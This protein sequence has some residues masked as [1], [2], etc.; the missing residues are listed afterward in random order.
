[1]H[2]FT[3]PRGHVATIDKRPIGD[4]A[5]AVDLP[6]TLPQGFSQQLIS[7]LNTQQ[8][9]AY[10]YRSG[11][12][13]RVSFVLSSTSSAQFTIRE[14]VTELSNDPAHYD[15]ASLLKME[16]EFLVEIGVKKPSSLAPAPAKQPSPPPPPPTAPPTP[17]QTN[18]MYA[19]SVVAA[20]KRSKSPLYPDADDIGKLL[21][22]C[23]N[24]AEI[25][26]VYYDIANTPMNGQFPRP[27]VYKIPEVAAHKS[28]SRNLSA[29]RTAAIDKSSPVAAANAKHVPEVVAELKKG[30]PDLDT[31]KI[32]TALRNCTKLDDV[33]EVYYD[34]TNGRNGMPRYPN[35]DY[36]QEVKAHKAALK[37]LGK[38]P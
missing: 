17:E 35:I 4:V 6:A 31:G 2:T 8:R 18:A 38:T 16:D 3:F 32:E 36:L 26:G 20:L 11:T 13:G 24:G 34:I 29:V 21:K 37:G 22:A 15:I 28:A 10:F 1:M 12:G 33:I 7:N 27:T 5:I 23:R 25:E 9:P 14:L 30:S 19:D